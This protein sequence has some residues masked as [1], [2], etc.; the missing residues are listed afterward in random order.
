[1]K[2]DYGKNFHSLTEYASA[3]PIHKLQLAMFSQSNGKGHVI[4]DNRIKVKSKFHRP[5][6]FRFVLMQPITNFTSF[7]THSRIR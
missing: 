3:S 6:S 7:R 4:L 1:M 2:I 5:F